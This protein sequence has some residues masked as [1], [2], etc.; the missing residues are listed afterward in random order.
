MIKTKILGLFYGIFLFINLKSLHLILFDKLITINDF[1]H[2]YA[3][4]IARKL[5]QQHKFIH[6]CD[7]STKINSTQ[8]AY[9]KAIAFRKSA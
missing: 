6:N 3:L 1:E 5:K 8:K 2:T 9:I 4:K 7:K